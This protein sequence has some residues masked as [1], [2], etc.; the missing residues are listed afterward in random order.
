[1]L[2][3][4]LA[5]F[6]YIYRIWSTTP[7]S[8]LQIDGGGGGGFFVGWRWCGGF[9]VAISILC[10]AYAYAYTGLH[11]K[12]CSVLLYTCQ[13]SC[14]WEMILG[15]AQTRGLIACRFSI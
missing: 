3:S 1:M 10:H 12:Y 4:V 15:S 8:R 2:R 11:I 6:I 5:A 14:A 7:F 9:S 13:Q